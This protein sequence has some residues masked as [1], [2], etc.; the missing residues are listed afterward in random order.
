MRE[1][2]FSNTARYTHNERAYDAAFR[3][4]QNPAWFLALSGQYGV[5]KTRLLAC[6]VNHVRSNG[7]TAVYST[8]AD[9]LDHLRA[10]YHPE[11][12]VTYDALWDRIATAK[13]VA[14][15]E[16]DRWNPTPWAKEK[17][18]QLMDVRYRAGRECLTVLA[19]NESIDRVPG[20]LQSRL[21][22]KRCSIEVINAPDVRRIRD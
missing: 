7:Q 17:F 11:A 21:R 5:G 20:Y 9:L 6:I 10:T 13:V 8:T 22:D 12:E 14:L 4:A 16:M 18:F 1:W 19:T 2:V 15:D 3:L